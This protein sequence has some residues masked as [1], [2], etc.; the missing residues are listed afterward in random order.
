MTPSLGDG[1][2]DRI[3]EREQQDIDRLQARLSPLLSERQCN[4]EGTMGKGQEKGGSI[5][6]ASCWMWLTLI[7]WPE[8]LFFG[9]SGNIRRFPC[10]VWHYWTNTVKWDCVNMCHTKHTHWRRSYPNM[11]MQLCNFL[12][13]LLHSRCVYLPFFHFYFAFL[14]HFYFVLQCIKG[15]VTIVTLKKSL[16]LS[17][18]LYLT[19]KIW[20][21]PSY[22]N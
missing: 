3:E 4:L 21:P 13:C 18:N 7:V 20:L 17:L 14:F 16:S 19:I 10:A 12:I 8:A 5:V 15:V 22:F 2:S 9:F 11:F 1:L 6:R